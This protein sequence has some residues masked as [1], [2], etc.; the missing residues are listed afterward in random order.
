M[1]S[2]LALHSEVIQNNFDVTDGTPGSSQYCIEVK[3][4]MLLDFCERLF[5][6]L[7][8]EFFYDVLRRSMKKKRKK[9]R[10]SNS[11]RKG[12]VCWV[13]LKDEK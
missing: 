10:K 7:W 9:I 8:S 13:I 11:T 3:E 4:E 2:L 5:L 12:M 1:C 6:S